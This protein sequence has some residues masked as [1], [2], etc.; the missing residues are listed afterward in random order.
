MAK[1]VGLGGAALFLTAGVAL[2]QEPAP[3]I[4]DNSFL[5]EEAYNQ[6]RGVVR[7]SC[8]AAPIRGPTP[9]P[10]NGR[11]SDSTIN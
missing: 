6:E 4:A 5:L 2:A 8:S 7:S 11:S 9:L 10:R 1:D 3:A